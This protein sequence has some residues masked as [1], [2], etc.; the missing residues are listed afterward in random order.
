MIYWPCLSLFF[1]ISNLICAEK[2]KLKLCSHVLIFTQNWTKSWCKLLDFVQTLPSMAG[3]EAAI[4]GIDIKNNQ[5]GAGT[6]I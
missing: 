5:L 6:C 2:S 3:H 1:A 4:I